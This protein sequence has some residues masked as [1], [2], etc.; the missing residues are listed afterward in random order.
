MKT[1]VRIIGRLIWGRG[2]AGRVWGGG[3]AG[4][5]RQAGQGV[6][7]S[8]GRKAEGLRGEGCRGGGKDYH[9]RQLPG[10]YVSTGTALVQEGAARGGS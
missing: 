3:A 8:M 5:G 9:S 1:V 4:K 7:G 6:G 10:R 2:K